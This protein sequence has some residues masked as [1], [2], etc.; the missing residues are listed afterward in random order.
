MGGQGYGCGCLDMVF[1]MFSDHGSLGVAS[2][3]KPI[4]KIFIS[5]TS[6]SSIIKLACY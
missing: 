1:D 5:T 3:N 4:C 2:Y 6:V